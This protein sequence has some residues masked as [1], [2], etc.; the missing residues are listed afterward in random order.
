MKVLETVTGGQVIKFYLEGEAIKKNKPIP[1]SFNLLNLDDPNATDQWLKQNDYKYG[2]L[3]GFSQWA[4]VELS[5]D[6][7]G[8]IAVVNHVF[9]LSRVLKNLAGT[10]ELE[11]WIPNRNP[12]PLW[13]GPLWAIE[14]RDELS[15]IL[16]PPTPGERSEG[17]AL[18]V[19]DGSGR[20]ICY[21][22]S[23]LRTGSLSRMR[24][25]IG[26]NPNSLSIFFRNELEKEFAIH[27][28]RYSTLENMLNAI[29][30]QPIE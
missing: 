24:G 16:R 27:A 3:S 5:V 20:S 22:R 18:Y 4:L 9:K 28:E 12:L 1:P 14:W 15:I 21:Y 19:E 6:D 30:I 7:L 2:V 13:Y 26:F 17:A 10:R 11:D 8:S 23:L 25:Y 29:D